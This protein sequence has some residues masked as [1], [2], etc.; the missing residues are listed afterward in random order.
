MILIANASTFT[1]QQLPST[2][3]LAGFCEEW[4]VMAIRNPLEY[5]TRED[6]PYLQYEESKF[7]IIF[8]HAYMFE[9]RCVQ[10]VRAT[11]HALFLFMCP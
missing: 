3:Q 1:G 10:C 6:H 11:L 5:N 7:S 8:Y 2:T 9:F 4:L